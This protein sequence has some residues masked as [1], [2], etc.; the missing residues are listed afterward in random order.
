VSNKY[1][2][3]TVYDKHISGLN[4]QIIELQ[5]GMSELKQVQK[6][7]GDKIEAKVMELTDALTAQDDIDDEH[8]RQIALI[9]QDMARLKSE[10]ALL[11]GKNDELLQGYASLDKQMAQGFTEIKTMIKTVSLVLGTLATLIT[12]AISIYQIVR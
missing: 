1:L 3:K 11:C 9:V 7:A 10:T 2:S 12:L 6:G 4:L 5:A 8:A